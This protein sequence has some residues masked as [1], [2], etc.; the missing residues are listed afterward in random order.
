MRP[1]QPPRLKWR[2]GRPG[3]ELGSWIIKDQERT[4][5]TGFGEGERAKAEI[6]LAEYISRTRQPSFGDGRPHQVLIGDCLAVYG[7]KHGPKIARPDGLA[8]EIERL[9]EF[10]GAH[11]V[12]EVT[13]GL[14]HAY[15]VWRTAQT[16]ARATVNKGRTIKPSTARRELVTLSAALNW[17]YKNKKLDRSVVVTL[18][19]VPEP[20]ER[21]L[22]RSELAAL[23]WATLGFNRD[24]TRNRFRIN[25]HLAR[26][27]LVGFYTG[28]RHDAILKLQWR[29]NTVGGWF[30]IDA[31]IL[32][33]RPQDA[34]ETNKRRTPCPIPPR[35]MPHLRRWCRFSTQYVVEYDG[36]PIA[37]QLRRAWGG[38]R[39]LAGLGADCTPHVLRHSCATL[40]LQNGVSTWRVA[41]LLGTSEQVIQRTYGH[42]CIEDLREAVGVWSTAKTP[43][44]SH[45]KPVNKARQTPSKL[46]KNAEQSR[47]V[48]ESVPFTRERS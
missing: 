5:R 11:T 34:I 37:S 26:F 15:T 23:L 30:D 18:P 21:Y 6:A 14:C 32:Y 22:K 25:R 17:C 36:K 47:A 8:V 7:D 28:T 33:R 9:A 44:E 19:P 42:H 4:I 31:G 40:L 2:R 46:T 24:G 10:F 27:I 39:K 16:D 20:R 1:I 41:R 45:R 29:A 12:T 35:L 48:A 38:A 13:P 3:K 43:P